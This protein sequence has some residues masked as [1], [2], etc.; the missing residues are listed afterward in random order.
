MMH[1]QLIFELMSAY[2][3]QYS[4]LAMV[5][6]VITVG[7]TMNAKKKGDKCGN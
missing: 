5:I 7:V 4:L 3:V 2:P 6:V 1:K